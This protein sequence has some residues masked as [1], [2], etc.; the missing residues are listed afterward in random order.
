MVTYVLLTVKNNINA[1]ISSAWAL[2]WEV[3][4]VIDVAG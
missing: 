3:E 2:S 1:R 4:P